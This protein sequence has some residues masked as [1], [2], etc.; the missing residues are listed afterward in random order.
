MSRTLTL[1]TA[2]PG[3]TVQDLGRP[4]YLAFGLSRG[5][6]ADRLALAEGGA[7]LGQDTSFAAIEMAGLGGTFEA[8]AEM[9]IAL[10]G[11]PM[12]AALDDGTALRWNASH[13]LPKGARLTV[14]AA[15]RGSYGYLHVGGGIATPDRLGARG[16]HL[17]AGLGARLQAGAVL[18]V[19]DD[20]GGPVNMALDPEP[21]LEGG[22]LRM[23]PSLQTELFGQAELI[24]FQ[25]TTFVRDSR[26]NRM[27]V[28]LLPEGAGFALDG[29][30]SVLSEVI[31]PGDIQVTGDGTPFI[32]MSECQ[33]TGGYPRIGSVI[34]SDLPRVAQAPAGAAF[35]FTLVSLAEAVQIER[36]AAEDRAR[37]PAR[38]APLLRDPAQIRDLL[39]YQL[40]SGVTAGTDLDD[41]DP[42]TEEGRRP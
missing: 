36:R 7:L 14:G 33:T 3:L 17:A 19:G 23:V 5:G 34:P 13:L 31:A 40:V 42:D 26:A 6:A 4:G 10:T 37:L 20:A 8:S 18:P 15:R 27:G 32:L 41:D 35:R 11:A 2:G 22:G 29:G 9:R 12:G 24:R 39:A 16:V 38:L 30:L 25:H 1:H 21:R 28:R